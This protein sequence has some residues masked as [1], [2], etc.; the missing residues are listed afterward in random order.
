MQVTPNPSATPKLQT[1]K[2]LFA[3]YQTSAQGLSSSEVQERLKQHGPNTLPDKKVSPFLKFVSYFWGPIAWM[4][5]LAAILSAIVGDWTD[6]GIILVLLLGNS[7]VGF[8]EEN[9]AG[10]AVAALKSQLAPQAIVLRDGDWKQI[11]AA[12]LVPGDIVTLKLGNIVPADAVLLDPDSLDID[13]A[14]LT[15]ESLPVSRGQSD[16]VYSGSIVKR[17]EAKAVVTGTGTN[18][19]FGRTAQL[20]VS[21]KTV[22][23]FQRSFMQLVDYLIL[24]AI[25]LVVIVFVTQLVKADLSHRNLWQEILQS[26]KFLLV[27]IVASIPIAAPVVL[28]LAMA[29]GATQLAKE[30]VIVQRLSSI[31]ELAGIDILCSDKTGTLTLN[32]LSLGEPLLFSGATRE[33]ALLAAALAS[34]QGSPDAIDQVILNQLKDPHLLKRYSIDHFTPFDPVSKRTEATVADEAGQSFRVSK[35]APQVVIALANDPDA[36]SQAEAH[37]QELAS[38]GYRALGVARTN[39][40]GQ[41]QLLAILSLSD[42]PRP[43]SA[44]TLQELK[45]LGVAVKMLTGDQVVIAKETARQLGLGTNILDASLL[46][47]QGSRANQQK[48]EDAVVAADGFGQVFPED[49]YAVVASLQDRGYLVG[50]TGDGVNDA[51]ALKKA[52]VGIAVSGATDAARSAAAVV[53]TAPG[54]SVVARAVRLSRLIFAR[55]NAYLIYRLTSTIWILFFTSLSILVFNDYPVT[56][57]M[58]LLLAIL[59]DGSF[60]TIAYDNG[61]I[62]RTPSRSRVGQIVAMAAILGSIGVL[63]SFLLYF[64]LRQG[65]QVPL[66]IM[67]TC[68][69]L[70]IA[71]GQTLTLYAVRTGGPF[72]SLRTTLPL[73]IATWAAMILSTL[74]ATFGVGLLTPLGWPTTGAIWFYTMIWFLIIDIV[75]QWIYPSLMGGRSQRL[76]K[77]AQLNRLSV[78]GVTN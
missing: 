11:D 28:S 55:M 62:S 73:G 18:T 6:F 24:L 74:I 59:N 77:L 63:E 43:D 15:G 61:K 3:K 40:Q 29:V 52:N 66:E 9:S 34:S 65:F 36:R 38:R 37:V 51:P 78:P 26:V 1:L 44:A 60:I 48:L 72:W 20:I 69:F 46:R 25:G 7:I 21:A 49:K 31:D 16:E 27:L 4:M 71:V 19:F 70:N 33:E 67:Q 32:Q 57:V 45:A 76:E 8:W 17:G 10:N 5:E 13:Q 41:W 23:T 58:I 54:L 50:M 75:K 12:G 30:K 64:I 22:S 42:P 68:L 14:A 39:D 35:G 47:E 2:N 56:A 53:L